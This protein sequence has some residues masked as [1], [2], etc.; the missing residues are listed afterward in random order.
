MDED[1]PKRS[2]TL[3]SARDKVD[4]FDASV[5]STKHL[6]KDFANIMLG[7]VGEDARDADAG[8]RVINW[9]FWND[10]QY[11][12]IKKNSFNFLITSR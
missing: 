3:I 10:C 4:T 6:F 8:S 5:T 9:H 12:P 2:P 1:P 7:D 11:K